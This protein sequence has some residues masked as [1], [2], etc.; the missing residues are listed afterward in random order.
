MRT[1]PGESLIHPSIGQSSRSHAGSQTLERRTLPGSM[2]EA[3]AAGTLN[4][5]LALCL[6]QERLVG[7]NP[8]AVDSRSCLHCHSVVLED[9]PSPEVLQNFVVRIPVVLI[10]GH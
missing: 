8:A 4:L 9:R 1:I 2:T 10:G 7:V 6:E 5:E 3:L